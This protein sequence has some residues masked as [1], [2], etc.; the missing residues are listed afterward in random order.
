MSIT[1][2]WPVTPDQG[3]YTSGAVTV[4]QLLSEGKVNVS[5]GS[6]SADALT[7]TMVKVKPANLNDTSNFL[8]GINITTV[9]AQTQNALLIQLDTGYI[10]TYAIGMIDSNQANLFLVTPAGQI[11]TA[12]TKIQIGLNSITWGA[13][14]PSTGT[15][16]Q[17]DICWNTGASGGGSPGWICS[18]AGTSGTW[19]TLANVGA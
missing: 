11:I 1:K 10:G 15:W 8:S 6:V 4:E 18:A 3:A 12:A 9:G 17:G 7:A 16:A 19:K 13:T 5:G 2:V 14:S